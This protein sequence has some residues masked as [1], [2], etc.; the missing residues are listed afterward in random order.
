MLRAY[1]LET[2][3]AG[4]EMTAAYERRDDWEHSQSERK[5]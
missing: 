4:I 1:E 2:E 3:A 5:N